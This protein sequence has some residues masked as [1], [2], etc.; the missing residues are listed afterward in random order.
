MTEWEDSGRQPGYLLS[1]QRLADYEG[2][3][4]TSTL[5][6]T[7]AEERFLDASLLRRESELAAEQERAAREHD[8]DRAARKGYRIIA[9]LGVLVAAAVVAGVVAFAGGSKPK[10]A[11][12]HAVAGDLGITDMI[13]A[14]VGRSERDHGIEVDLVQPLVDVEED[15]RRLAEAGTDLVVVS[16]E[17]DL[18][19]E[20]V[21]GE[22]PDVQWVAVDPSAVHLE[23]PNVTELQF[24]VAHSGFLAGSAAAMSS[25][26]GRVGFIGGFQTFRTE[27]SRSGFE[28]GAQSAD[29]DIVV[30]SVY[31]GPVANPLLEAEAADEL[32]AEVAR[33]MYEG[34]VDVIFHNAGAAGAGVIRAAN[35]R[36]PSSPVWTIGS[37]TDE[38][39]T[40]P[41]N[42]RD[43]V[44]TSTIKR[45]DIA[46]ELAIER[47]MNDELGSG[48]LILGLADEGVG[49]SR[50]GG[51][52]AAVD[53]QLKMLEGELELDHIAVSPAAFRPPG[54]Q[55]EPAVA[56]TLIRTDDACDIDEVRAGVGGAPTVQDN[57]LMVERGSI[58]AVEVI[59]A[60]SDVTGLAVRTVPPGTTVAELQEEARIRQS[61]PESLG[62]ILG[63]STAQLGGRTGVAAL[64]ADSPLA[65]NC[66]GDLSAPGLNDRYALIV[67][68][69]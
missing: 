18:A 12:V 15:L 43:V 30:E 14:G 10:V 54:W 28:Q 61:I 38:F 16:R 8:L 51:R 1:G 17:F 11:V 59:N 64:V 25:R 41:G 6:L 24:D 45:F 22:F 21:A 13:I 66:L 50:A 58:V 42:E 46:V 60:S 56:I 65:L 27:Q 68:P 26:T 48:E 35:E 52:L 4:A 63:M 53:G 23:L 5:R 40:L 31:V 62:L 3:A 67:S 55:F 34:G 9:V 19:V 47:F 33:R 49:V 37:D 69:T 20:N 39:V 7:D 36:S 29:P 2:W 44:L 32:A 57:R